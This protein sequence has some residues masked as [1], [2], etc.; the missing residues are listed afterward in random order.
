[1]FD[2]E[3]LKTLTVMYVEDDDNI[4]NSLSGILTK[5]F[6]EVIICNDGAVGI[7]QFTSYAVERKLKI[8]VIISDINMPNINGIEMVK[9]IRALDSEIPIIFTTAHGEASYL[10]DAIKLKIAYYALKP[11]DTAELLRQISKFCMIERDK[12]LLVKKEREISQYMNIMNNVSSI[13]KIDTTGQIIESNDMLSEVSGYLNSEL[14][15]IKIDNIL[16]D[17][18]ITTN[19]N[20]LLKILDNNNEYKG[21]IKFKSKSNDIFYL[22]LTI[23][24]SYNKSTSLINGYI[25]IGFDQ[26][27]DELAKQQTMQKVRQN[28]MSQRTKETTL[29]KK[30]KE[31]ENQVAILNQSSLKNGDINLIMEK[32]SKEKQKVVKLNSQIEHYE[33]EITNLL[34]QKDDFLAGTH[35]KKEKQQQKKNDSAKEMKRLQTKIIELQSKISKLEARNR[36]KSYA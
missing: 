23:I 16:H 9:S 34:S 22:N 11:I 18:S 15:N 20:D 29:I 36:P 27:D 6:K 7:E 14:L 5:I 12:Q 10:M 32:L 2:K 21:K 4:R 13:F 1:M 31:L 17:D 33:R 30:V 8:D 25:C 24:P 26:T 19:Y 35:D 28:I 3:F